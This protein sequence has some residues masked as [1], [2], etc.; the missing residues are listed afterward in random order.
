MDDQRALL[1]MLMGKT[2][3][4]TDDVKRKVSAVNFHDRDVCK[5]YLCGLCPY[6]LFSATKSDLGKCP[7]PICDTAEA[8]SLKERYALLPQHEKD[9]DGYEYELYKFL[10]NLIDTCDQR[11][12]RNKKRAEKDMQVSD[13]ILQKITSLET[14]IRSLSDQC[15]SY[16]EVDDNIDEAQ[17]LSKRIDTL[18]SELEVLSNPKDHKMVT[19]CDVSGNFMSTKDNDERMRSH[20][21]GKQY[22]GWKLIRDHYRQMRDRS[23]RPSGGGG[24]GSAGA[25]GAHSRAARSSSRDRERDRDRDR[26]RDRNNDRDRDRDRRR[27]R[28]SSRDNKDRDNKD[29][30]RDSR[31]DRSYSRDRDRVRDRDRDREKSSRKEEGRDDRR[32]LPSS[33]SNRDR[34]R[35]RDRSSDRDRDR[36]RDRDRGHERESSKHTGRSLSTVPESRRGGPHL[37]EGEEPDD[38]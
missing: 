38:F 24:S 9:R 26:D 13:E 37:E 27:A 11:V 14:E 32:E 5:F 4:L 29:R 25:G 8:N 2:R 34:D 23:M 6:T 7:K 18:R 3:N 35:D 21:E 12:N 36:V 19:V 30:N 20:F 31:R 1:D 15:I 16:V 33:S 22:I 17:K 28:S 10:E